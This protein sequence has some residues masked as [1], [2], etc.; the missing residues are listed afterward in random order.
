MYVYVFIIYVFVEVAQK[1][2][3]MDEYIN[4]SHSTSTVNIGNMSVY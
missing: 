3:Y 1:D 4:K 2:G